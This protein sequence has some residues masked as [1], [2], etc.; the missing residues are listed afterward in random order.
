MTASVNNDSICEKLLSLNSIRF[1]SLFTHLSE[2]ALRDSFKLVTIQL[3]RLILETKRYFDPK[4]ISWRFSLD[5][6]H[7][8][9]HSDRMNVSGIGHR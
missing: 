6:I 3:K 8:E 5:V 1:E 2:S 7:S 9:F 4:E